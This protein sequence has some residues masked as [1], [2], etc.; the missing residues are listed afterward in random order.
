MNE[1]VRPPDDRPPD[2]RPVAERPTARG[3]RRVARRIQDP[4]E[5]G[6]LPRLAAPAP[7]QSRLLALPPPDTAQ[8]MRKRP[9]R[10]GIFGVL[11][12]GTTKITCLIGRGDSDG[13]LRVMGCGWQRSR[14]VRLGGITD[15]AEA[16][17]AIRAA[18]GQAESQADHHLRSVTVNL[19]CGQP[20]SR[21]FNVRWPVG[22][23][24]VTD[25]DIRRVVNEGRNR[26][27]TEGRDVI[28]ALPLA[29]SVDETTG[30]EDPRGH[31]CEQ[32]SARLHVIDASSMALRNLAAVLARCDLD[33]TELVAAPLASGLSVLVE[34]ER[35]LGA[36]VVDM[37]GGTT[38]MAVFAEGQILHTS[39]LPVG[40]LHVTKDIAGMIS[41]PLGS[42]E[43]L[44]VIYGN[45]E[46]SSDDDR[47]MLN[48]QLIGED[49]HQFT[50]MAR[51][52]IVSVI[53]P[54]LEET[55]ELVRDRLDG[56]GL[57]RAAAGRVVLTGGASQLDGIT[58]MAAR[59]LNR[60]VRL[61]RPIG[62]RGLPDNATGPGFATPVGLLA[63]AA[64]AGRTL[65]DI[66]FNEPRPPGLVRR[67]VEFLRERV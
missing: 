63:W 6:M 51:S 41:T 19:S 24:A 12:I 4:T 27:V 60:Q 2:D 8:I 38:S 44:K 13:T 31:H 46:T 9:Y 45:A 52:R 54:R 49:E 48:V 10:P 55:F 53:R 33:I 21:L 34:D 64:G 59:I 25:A 26:A 29:F 15:L 20:E 65:H 58:P 42:A 36:T 56:A 22:G 3:G 11:D 43:R 23:R 40:G 16:E 37:G 39:Q 17:R 50:R 1:L 57:G 67:L 5:P 32:L 30:V 14:G 28:H 47:E 66:D 35:E 62:V 7:E 18:V 61:G